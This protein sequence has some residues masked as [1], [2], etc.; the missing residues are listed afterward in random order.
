MAEA[1]AR[2]AAALRE[3]TDALDAM[4]GAELAAAAADGAL[5]IAAIGPLPTA[6][7]RRVI[8]S[9]LL[10]GGAKNLTDRQIRGVDALLTSWRGQGGVA[11]GCDQPNTRLFA[12][13]SGAILTLR[14][15]G[16]IAHTGRRLI[17]LT[18]GGMARCRGRVGP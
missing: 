12:E 9:W 6:V 16:L 1:L 14:L 7:R 5:E 8:R 11:V 2:T 15:P 17:V 3:D 10:A 18:G 13:R 4:A